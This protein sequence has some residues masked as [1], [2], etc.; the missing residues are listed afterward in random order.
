M[1]LQLVMGR[2][3]LIDEC[4]TPLYYESTTIA[5]TIGSVHFQLA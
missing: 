3:V 1:L 5:T 2:I 4:Y